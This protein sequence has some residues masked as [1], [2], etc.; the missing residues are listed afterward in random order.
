MNYTM[1][2]VDDSIHKWPK[3]RVRF[4][5]K[6]NN[7]LYGVHV[8]DMLNCDCGM[9]GCSDSSELSGMVEDLV[10]IGLMRRYLVCTF[11]SDETGGVVDDC[12][13]WENYAFEANQNEIIDHFLNFLVNSKY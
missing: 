3:Q 10:N 13:F 8:R 2:E 6:Y 5:F 4:Y 9:N 11:V 1:V 7:I 12:M